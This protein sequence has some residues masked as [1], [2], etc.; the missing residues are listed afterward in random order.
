MSGAARRAR[1]RGTRP[2]GALGLGALGLGAVLALAA[3]SSGGAATPRTEAAAASTLT[4]SLTVFAAASL[5]GAFDELAADFASENPGVTVAPVTYDG[6]STLATQ[7]VEG[8]SADVFASAD[9]A[10]MATVADAGLVSGAP[11]VFTT[12]TLQIV[13]AAGNPSGVG[14]LADLATL[15]SSGGTVVLCAPEVP[16]GSAARTALDAAGVSLTPSSEEQNVT[17]V[18][19]KVRTG[20]ADAG[21]VYRT[22][23]LSAGDDVEGVDFAES[24]AARNR[25]PIALLDP[26]TRTHDDVVAQAFVDLVLSDAGQHVLADHGFVAP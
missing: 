19:T 8:A 22:D 11:T 2:L 4:G 24:A 18:L 17:A 3:C 9:Q 7:L 16:C 5:Q 20:D 23:V 21:I 25:Y 13:V 12:N 26:P 14:A 15:A 10:T 6:S 1:R